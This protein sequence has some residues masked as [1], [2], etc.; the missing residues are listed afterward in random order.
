MPLTASQQAILKAAAQFRDIL[1]YHGVM[2][3]KHA[4]AFPEADLS[5][6]VDL[7]LLEWAEFTYGC[8]K[9]LKG[10]RVTPEG[11]RLLDESAGPHHEDPACELAYEHMLILQDVFHFGHM[12]RYR[13]MMPA[14]KA[15][16]YVSSDF[17]D[18]LNRGYVLKMKLKVEG[19]R[20]LKG[21]V[22]SAKGERALKQAGM[23]A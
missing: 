1:K 7:G 3:L 11:L 8:G 20:T 15:H 12:P 22:I 5:V 16:A 6:L 10:L 19:E 2:P 18:L 14:K 23:T 4:L 13:R 17:E 9:E 21:Y